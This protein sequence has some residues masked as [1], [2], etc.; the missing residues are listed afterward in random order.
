MQANLIRNGIDLAI[1]ER[2]A[3]LPGWAIEHVPLDGGDNETGEPSGP[4]EA[5][6]ARGAARDASVFAY[7]GP[8]TSGAA[9]VSLPILNQ[10]GLL[11]AL[12][13]ASWPGLTQSG[14]AYNEPNRYYPSG[15]Q[16]AVRLMPADSAQSRGAAI[17]AR[18]LGAT[19]AIVLSD[20][21]DYSKGMA[22]A[23]MD[24]AAKLGMIVVGTVSLT[25]PPPDWR[26]L[27]EQADVVFIA[28]SSLSIADTA[29]EFIAEDPPG[30]AIFATDLLLSD[31]LSADARDLMEG[32]YTTFNGVLTPGAS[33]TI[34]EFGD[35]FQD[36]FG[37]PPSQYAVNAYDLTAAV[38]EAAANVGVDRHRLLQ[39]VLTGEH[40]AGVGGPLSFE[41]NGDRQGG[42]LTLYRLLDGD[43]ELLGE[44]ESP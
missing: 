22:A 24:E 26:K 20:E 40:Q 29:A 2:R 23:F 30:V 10:A 35:R 28:P 17:E 42:V 41:P 7:V 9:M 25:A 8:Y 31:R 18:E 11:Q 36:R 43:F 14:W 13:V 6:N 1:E 16:H 15:A 19:S 34:S 4:V 37:V 33:Q 27:V 12:P 21:S 39:A 38:L 32:W 3:L 5:S 44:I